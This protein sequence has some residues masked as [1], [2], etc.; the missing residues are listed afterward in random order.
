MNKTATV[1]LCI[2]LLLVLSG[3][4]TGIY[5]L[6][7][8]EKTKDQGYIFNFNDGTFT[9]KITS[10]EVTAE[11]MKLDKAQD[12]FLVVFTPKDSKLITNNATLTLEKEIYLIATN[13]AFEIKLEYNSKSCGLYF[14]VKISHYNDFSEDEKAELISSIKAQYYPEL[15]CD[16]VNIFE[17]S[18]MTELNNAIAKGELKTVKKINIVY[19]EEKKSVWDKYYKK[20]I[21]YAKEEIE[22]EKV[23]KQYSNI[24]LSITMAVDKIKIDPMV[25]EF[26][27]TITS[28]KPLFEDDYKL[29][30]EDIATAQKYSIKT[31]QTVTQGSSFIANVIWDG[32]I[33]KW[34]GQKYKNA[35]FSLK[36][37]DNKSKKV[38]TDQT[39]TTELPNLYSETYTYEMLN[40]AIH[41]KDYA[42]VELFN[43]ESKKVPLIFKDKQLDTPQISASNPSITVTLKPTYQICSDCLEIYNPTSIEQNVVDLLDNLYFLDNI[44]N[45]FLIEQGVFEKSLNQKQ[46]SALKTLIDKK[47]IYLGQPYIATITPEF[48]EN[49]ELINES[50]L[51]GNFFEKKEIIINTLL[52]SDKLG[53]REAITKIQSF[54]NTGQKFQVLAEIADKIRAEKQSSGSTT[55]SLGMAYDITA[56]D[57]IYALKNHKISCISG[58]IIIART[59]DYILKKS[60]EQNY[61]VSL[62]DVEGAGEFWEGAYKGAHI[63]TKVVLNHVIQYFDATNTT[64]LS[65]LL[66]ITPTNKK[67]QLKANDSASTIYRTSTEHSIED[68]ET[69]SKTQHKVINGQALTTQEIKNIPIDFLPIILALYSQSNQNPQVYSILQSRG[70]TTTANLKQMQNI[71]TQLKLNSAIL[72]YSHNTNSEIPSSFAINQHNIYLDL[73]KQDPDLYN[74]INLLGLLTPNIIAYNKIN[75][76]KNIDSDWIWFTVLK[77][78]TQFPINTTIITEKQ[79]SDAHK[80][81]FSFPFCIEICGPEDQKINQYSYLSLGFAALR[82]RM[83]YLNKNNATEANSLKTIIT[84]AVDYIDSKLNPNFKQKFENPVIMYPPGADDKTKEI[85]KTGE[86]VGIYAS[87]VNKTV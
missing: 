60:G 79:L 8:N 14:P 64:N 65:H 84:E 7:I 78:I 41:Q 44:D 19:F 68:A 51:V 25:E 26:Y 72:T 22:K 69:L 23:K 11:L 66:I 48:I 63:I 52:I 67:Y 83:Y 42:I 40:S 81:I 82:Y 57:Y 87:E 17:K 24:K 43:H 9:K 27:I 34:S 38:L 75:L 50:K 20:A 46:I 62:V 74:N 85:A 36:V 21:N 29:E 56:S 70:I 13:D 58:G 10:D 31:E 53:L 33:T 15:D 59:I 55:N 18:I 76:E 28:N 86:Q 6:V 54:A 77:T 73:Y 32:S 12:Y 80:I 2:I 3:I 71:Y 1:I 49:T 4:I 45:L 35:N 30:A 16:L 5:F 37:I 47:I 61:S 39:I